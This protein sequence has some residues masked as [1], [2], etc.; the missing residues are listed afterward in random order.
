MKR[1]VRGAASLQRELLV[2][3]RI[4]YTAQ[5]SD[6]VI[7]TSLLDYLQVFRISGIGFECT[8]DAQLNSWHERLNILWRN[9]ASP[10]VALWTHVI[11]RR[12]DSRNAPR[13]ASR[14][15]RSSVA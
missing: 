4:P 14:H 11:R 15:S 6:T 3:E 13:I 9:I 2:A 10:N 8:D 7:R 5:L 1:L 12:E